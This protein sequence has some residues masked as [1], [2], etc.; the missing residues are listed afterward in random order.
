MPLS[1]VSSHLLD[2]TNWFIGT[3]MAEPELIPWLVMFGTVAAMG[4]VGDDI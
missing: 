4:A 2:S 1:Q 3:E